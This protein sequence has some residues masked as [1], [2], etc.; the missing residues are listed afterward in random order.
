MSI[1]PWE[2]YFLLLMKNVIKNRKFWFP[3]KLYEIQKNILNKFVHLKK[4]YKLTSENFLIGHIVFVLIVKKLTKM[5]NSI[6]HI[7]CARYEKNVRK[8]NCSFQKGL[9]INC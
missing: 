7:I 6:L 5:E 9:Q 8:E 4:I 1:F 3:K 2:L